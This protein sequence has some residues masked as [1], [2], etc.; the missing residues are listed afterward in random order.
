MLGDAIGSAFKIP[1]VT[2][3]INTAS[4]VPGIGAGMSAAEQNPLTAQLMRQMGIGGGD[5]TGQPAV[6]GAGAEGSTEPFDMESFITSNPQYKF[7]QG[8]GIRGMQR[9]AAAKGMFGSGN[10]LR[11]LTSFSS[12]LASS[13]YNTEMDRIMAM[14]GVG[15]GSPGSAGQI[16]SS[17][18]GQSAMYGQQAQQSL[19]TGLGYGIGWMANQPSAAPAPGAPGNPTW[20]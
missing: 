12:G 9:S 7:M 1:G 16:Y 20:V 8:E 2:S 3:A 4:Q 18:M 10:L 11:D 14:A 6:P 19:G 5:V 13:S 15:A 17:G